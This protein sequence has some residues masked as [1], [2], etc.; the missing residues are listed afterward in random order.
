MSD[1]LNDSS[2]VAGSRDVT[3]N[4]VVYTATNWDWDDETTEVE[5]SD[6]NNII[7]GVKVIR[8]NK[9]SGTGT[10]QLATTATPLPPMFVVFTTTD[11]DG[12]TVNCYLTK[13]G[14]KEV[15]AGETT[16]PVSFRKAVGAVVIS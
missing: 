10:L 1:I 2:V 4:S 3:I 13:R 7:S 16:V 11:I 15:N 5:R 12:A 6:K 14:R 8:R 9:Q